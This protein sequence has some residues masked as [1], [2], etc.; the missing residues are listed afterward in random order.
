MTSTTTTTSYLMFPANLYLLVQKSPIQPE[1]H[2]TGG[3]E[4]ATT[5]ED[6]QEINQ[7]PKKMSMYNCLC[8]R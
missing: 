4:R 1:R 2:C 8:I 5:E 6:G 7:L 3:D